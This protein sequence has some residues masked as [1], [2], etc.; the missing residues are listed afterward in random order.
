MRPNL[1]TS[2]HRFRSVLRQLSVL[3][4]VLLAGCTPR[5]SQTVVA[6]LDGG[7]MLGGA[8]ADQLISIWQAQLCRYVASEGGDV[9]AALSELRRLRSPNV[10]R[11]ARIRF[12]VLDIDTGAGRWDIQGVL[13][14]MQKH[15]PFVRYVFV[16]GIV[17]HSAYLSSELRDLRVVVLSPVGKTLVWE[18][19][20]ADR[21]AVQ[22]YRETFG[23][24]AGSGFPADDDVFRVQAT[25]DRVSVRE[26]RSGADWSLA[27]RRN[28][29]D[30]RGAVVSV[31]RSAADDAESDGCIPH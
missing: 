21:A 16:V 7:G 1:S 17:G 19:S 4:L 10:L 27:V 28:L 30:T 22:R 15:G 24:A 20:A 14:G 11:P 12:G 5:S 31:T 25:G 18:T 23:V 6:P 13:A 26:I 29:R 3:L 9:E 8:A 2:S